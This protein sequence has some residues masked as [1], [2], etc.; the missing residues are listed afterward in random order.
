[1]SNLTSGT[2]WTGTV[3]QTSVNKT[4][5][6]PTGKKYVDRNI[7]FQ[8]NVPGVV[9]PTP[10]S[11]TNTFYITI[12]EA[13]YY[14]RVDSS[15]NVW[16][17]ADG[18]TTPIASSSSG[19]KD[20]STAKDITFYVKHL[21]DESGTNTYTAK[22]GQ[23]WADAALTNSAHITTSVD[24]DGNTLYNGS[25]YTYT[26]TLASDEIIDGATYHDYILYD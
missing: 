8:I 5:E 11:G 3:E 26:R 20:F 25:D 12:G 4:Y 15:G 23:T 2:Q 19:T 14:W 7:K 13:T 16:V 1:M 9:I 17:D 21:G 6:F 24:V 10:A 22:E 18:T